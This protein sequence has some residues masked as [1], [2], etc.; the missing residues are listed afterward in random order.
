MKRLAVLLKP[1]KVDAIT[2]ALRALGLESTI[3]DVKG[4]G[5]EKQRETSGRG[6]MYV[7]PRIYY[8]ESCGNGSQIR[9]CR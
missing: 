8:K 7:R 3:Y 5:K 1:E 2:S 6:T 9:Y 4:A